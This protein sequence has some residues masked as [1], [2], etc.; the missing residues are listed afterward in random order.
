MSTKAQPT[1]RFLRRPEAR[2]EE[3]LD[4]ALTVFG[5][6]GYRATTLEQVARHAGVSKGTVYLYF[7]SKDALFRA[8][9]ERN[10]IAMIE[11]AE[12][13]ARQHTGTATAL[14]ESMV[15]EMWTA[16]SQSRIVCLTRLVQSELPHFPEIQR[17]Y[18]ENVIQRHRRLLRTIVERG[19]ASGEFR[20]E[21]RAIVPTML[22][23]LMVHL[24]HV[25]ALFGGLDPDGP[26]PESQVESILS[27]MFDGIRLHTVPPT[28]KG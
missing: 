6:R 18:W 17:Y 27:L 1:K 19:I 22:P 13:R 20:P 12:T 9:V 25:R 21:A 28:R 23:S 4:A 24:N 11:V 16:L 14:L 2:P 3:L 10:V 26:T 5:Q 8:M 7:A 15:R